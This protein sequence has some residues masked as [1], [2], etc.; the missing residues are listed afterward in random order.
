MSI[1]NL[2]RDPDLRIDVT[3]AETSQNLDGWY[4]SDTLE[5]IRALYEATEDPEAREELRK[6]YPIE[7]WE[8]AINQYA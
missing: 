2:E 5:D 3:E 4:A 6:L 7:V 8:R 1:R